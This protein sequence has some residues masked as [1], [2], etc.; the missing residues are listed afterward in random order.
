MHNLAENNKY[1]IDTH[2]I[3]N[4]DKITYLDNDVKTI[5]KI[6]KDKV[7]IQRDNEEFSHTMIYELNKTT[8]SNYFLK[9]LK[10]SFSIFVHTTSLEIKDNYLKISYQLEESKKNKE[11]SF[12]NE[13]KFI[14]LLE[15]SDK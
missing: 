14:Y 1:I 7:I 4:K 15:V 5:I 12:N 3:K 9:E 2:G 8:E 11:P 6:S 13:N 10:T